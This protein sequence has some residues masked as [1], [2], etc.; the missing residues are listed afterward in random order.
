MKSKES[1]ITFKLGGVWFHKLASMF[2]CLLA[3]LGLVQNTSKITHLLISRIALQ[4]TVDKLLINNKNL[5]EQ[6]L[7]LTA[8]M[9]KCLHT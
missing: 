4:E 5:K 8:S 9:L 3:C 2:A 7:N 1:F 6:S